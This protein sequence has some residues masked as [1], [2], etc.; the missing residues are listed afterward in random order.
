MYKLLLLLLPILLFSKFQVTTTL[1]F[2][3]HIIK[4][5]GQNYIRIK[6]ISN[7][8]SNKLL[9]LSPS[10][11]SSLANTRAY[12][13]FSLEIEKK[14]E[15]LFLKANNKLNIVNMSKN[16]NKIKYNG[17][18]NLY[19][20]LD[21]ILLRDVARNIY[22]ALVKIDYYNKKKYEENYKR[23]LQE[24]DN[25]FLK[26]KRKLANSEIYN[27]FVFDE[28]FDY[29]AKRF[30]INLYRKKKRVLSASEI[31]SLVKEVEINDIKAVF[32]QERQNITFA[33]SLS[34][35]S[36]ISIKTYNIYEEILFY[37]LSKI[38]Q[39]F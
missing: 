30:K 3:A 14:Y 19:V 9:K 39:E 21:P 36:N 34:G 35:N 16:I 29:F 26:T 17:K 12:Y 33:K 8:Y 24:L 4:Q 11:V 22:E 7:T 32:I 27:I 6:T 18:D 28:K 10:E 2:E 15:K 25:A 13:N 5:I 38:A 1:P 37:N 31:K 23:F 20:W